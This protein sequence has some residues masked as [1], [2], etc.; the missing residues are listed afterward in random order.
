MTETYAKIIDSFTN[1]DLDK[2]CR[3]DDCSEKLVG[4][5]IAFIFNLYAVIVRTA[6][7]MGE[8]DACTDR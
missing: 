7:D 6:R 2:M 5:G 8:E 3:S 1:G 4:C